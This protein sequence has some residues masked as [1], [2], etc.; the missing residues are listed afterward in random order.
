MGNGTR[1]AIAILILFLAMVCFFFAFHPGGV[2][3]V[4]DPDTM[5]QW[6]MGEFEN[7]SSGNPVTADQIANDVASSPT[8]PG[9]QVPPSSTAGQTTI[10]GVNSPSSQTQPGP[11]AVTPNP[12]NNPGA[13]GI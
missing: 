13:F 4:S 2:Q 10:P 12:F 11:P 9:V 3:G 1:L 6:L 5:L 7:T 8:A